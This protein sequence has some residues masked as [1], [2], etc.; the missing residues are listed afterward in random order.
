MT[1]ATLTG[2]AFLTV[3]EPYSIIMD[4]GPAAQKQV[5]QKVQEAGHL[6]GDMFEISTIRR[7]DYA[8]HKGKIFWV[9]FFLSAS[10]FIFFSVRKVNP[11]MKT[12]YS[13]TT[14]RHLV[15]L[16]AIKPRPHSSFL[17]LG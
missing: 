3:G 10:F 15:P 5:S 14:C 17:L 2:H 12:F 13:V 9:F 8:F 7:E 6:M 11:S 16:V 1:I 4:N